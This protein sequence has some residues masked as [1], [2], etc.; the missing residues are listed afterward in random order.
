[1]AS[2]STVQKPRALQIFLV[3]YVSKASKNLIGVLRDR[4]PASF[5][6]MC[7]IS[8]EKKYRARVV[9]GKCKELKF[10]K[11]NEKS[12]SI[13]LREFVKNFNLQPKFL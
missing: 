1:M 13:L 11:E 12:P 7:D 2:H 3:C 4:F 9:K 5:F 8:E 6:F 10:V